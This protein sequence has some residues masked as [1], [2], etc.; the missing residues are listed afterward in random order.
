LGTI[1]A[2]ARAIA[3]RWTIAAASIDL[4]HDAADLDRK[5]ECPT[6]VFYGSAGVMARLFD[7][8]AEWRK[9]CAHVTDRS[10]PGGHFFVDQ[11]AAETATVLTFLTTPA[12]LTSVWA[13]L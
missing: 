3:W 5:I 6:L 10:L 7:I 4:E 9:R 13:R 8:P 1:A 2:A 12:K 11:F